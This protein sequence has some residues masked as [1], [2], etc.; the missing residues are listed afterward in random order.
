VDDG[1]LR[2]TRGR[3]TRAALRSA[4]PVDMEHRD[5]D[6]R[7]D[8]VSFLLGLMIDGERIRHPEGEVETGRSDERP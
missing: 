6:L 7:D 5:V 2:S 8:D 3:S 1:R 4:S